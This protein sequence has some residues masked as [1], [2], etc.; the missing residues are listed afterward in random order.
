M[1]DLVG[2]RRQVEPEALLA[3]DRCE[4]AEMD[5]PRFIKRDFGFPSRDRTAC[6]F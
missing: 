4:K 2:N 5:F 6:R 1:H 3:A